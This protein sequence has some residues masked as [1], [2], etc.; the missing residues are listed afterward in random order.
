[1]C[2]HVD[3]EGGFIGSF[4][5]F[6]TGSTGSKVKSF[7]SVGQPVGTSD[8]PPTPSLGSRSGFRG[9]ETGSGQW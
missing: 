6:N 2:V 7:L 3:D 4:R 5:Q 9:W 1:M 8:L